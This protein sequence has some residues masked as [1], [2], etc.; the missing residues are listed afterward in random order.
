MLARR[1][2]RST[3]PRRGTLTSLLGSRTFDGTI[4]RQRRTCPSPTPTGP[5]G[6]GSS[7][8]AY[9]ILTLIFNVSMYFKRM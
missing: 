9:V 2:G 3:S 5:L 1:R 8:S 4:A 6:L 7:N